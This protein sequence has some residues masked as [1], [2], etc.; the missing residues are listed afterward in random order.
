MTETLSAGKACAFSPDITNMFKVYGVP[1]NV[2][3]DVGDPLV[4]LVSD[5]EL[6]SLSSF[7]FC[8]PQ[9]QLSGMYHSIFSVDLILLPH[10]PVATTTWS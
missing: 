9:V 6:T 8:L 3:V 5:R 4:F 7:A 1:R 2:L 10:L